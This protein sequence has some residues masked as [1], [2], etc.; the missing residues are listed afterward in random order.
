MYCSCLSCIFLDLLSFPIHKLNIKLT[1]TLQSHLSENNTTEVDCFQPQLPIPLDRTR[2][3]RKR[4]PKRFGKRRGGSKLFTLFPTQTTGRR[5]MPNLVVATER[6][7]CDLQ[8][9]FL[10][11]HAAKTEPASRRSGSKTAPKVGAKEFR[12]KIM[13]I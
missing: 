7:K 11:R 5:H 2:T 1:L 12:L 10:H 3:D 8:L 6:H 4:R 13:Q 9:L